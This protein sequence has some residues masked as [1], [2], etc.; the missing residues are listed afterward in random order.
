MLPS[1]KAIQLTLQKQKNLARTP[2]GWLFFFYLLVNANCGHGHWLQPLWSSVTI[3]QADTNFLFSLFSYFFMVSK[4]MS[5]LCLLANHQVDENSAWH[6]QSILFFQKK[7]H[8]C[9]P[10]DPQTISMRWVSPEFRWRPAGER[11]ERL[12]QVILPLFAPTAPHLLTLVLSNLC[13]YIFRS[14]FLVRDPNYIFF[15]KV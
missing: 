8:I 12:S 14:L 2:E 7:I 6:L 11:M 9:W 15:P 10:D 3:H 4:N 1:I 5:I 13:K